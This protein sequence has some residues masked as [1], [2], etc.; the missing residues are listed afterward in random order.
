M[1][2]DFASFF[3]ICRLCQILIL[4]CD[5]KF[6]NGRDNF[7]FG[8][9]IKRHICD[10]KNWGLGHDL[11][12]SVNGRVV[13]P[14]CESF[15]FTKLRTCENKTL[16]KIFELQYSHMRVNKPLKKPFRQSVKSPRKRGYFFSLRN[17]AFRITN[18]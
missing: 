9:S 3:I 1:L 16:T 8:N 5:C 14:F 6:R 17:R 10:I 4:V 7:I 11:P 2:G 18:Q 12:I 13:A 15:I